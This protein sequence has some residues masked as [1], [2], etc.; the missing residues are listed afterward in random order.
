MK[1][2]SICIIPLLLAVAACTNTNTD[3]VAPSEDDDMRVSF[4]TY[5]E[6]NGTSPTRAT[7]A[8]AN[9]IATDISTAERLQQVGFGVFA[10]YT[11]N[12]TYDDVKATAKPNFFWN[13]QVTYD[14][15]NGWTYSPEKYWPNEHGSQAISTDKDLISFF[16]Y[17]PFVKAAGS[18]ADGATATGASTAITAFS[19]NSVTGDPY[20]NYKVSDDA[21]QSQDLLWGVASSESKYLDANGDWVKPT[22]GLPNLNFSKQRTTD[23]VRFRFK[24]ALYRLGLTVK[25]TIGNSSANA[26]INPQN[27]TI[28]LIKEVKLK[29]AFPREAR[30]NLYNTEAN[31]P[32]W[33]GRS[34]DDTGASTIDIT[35]ALMNSEIADLDYATSG[36]G[37]AWT[38]KCE[39]GG[40]N[41]QG[42]QL[43]PSVT[44]ED[45][46]SETAYITMIPCT[47]ASAVTVELTYTLQTIDPSLVLTG[48]YARQEH[49]LTQTID[50]SGYEAGKTYVLNLVFNL[51][52][53]SFTVDTEE[54]KEPIFFDPEAHDWVKDD[55]LNLD[56]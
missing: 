25:T 3:V 11:D 55:D 35:K 42:K 24:H 44:V 50:F 17:A 10:Y 30:L 4:G 31:T 56:F 9:N 37:D 7:D 36:Q 21:T 16:A 28:V 54:W 15:T 51:Q 40:V 38:A 43:L 26:I 33:Q 2:C 27:G 5:V 19:A 52:E 22:E 39:G 46:K 20:V 29:G 32:N 1:R 47:E 6:H 12:Q 34:Y 41:S 8:T 48:G 45:G 14:A 18:T 13:Q 53:M 49:T 23:K